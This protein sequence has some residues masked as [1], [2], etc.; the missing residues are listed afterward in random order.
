MKATSSNLLHWG[1]LLYF[2]IPYLIFIFFFRSTLEF[3]IP[4]MTWALKNSLFQAGT[5]AL[6]SLVLA[7]PFSQGLLA[8]PLKWQRTLSNLLLL[9]QVLPSLYTLL[10]VFSLLRPFPMG[11]IG[12][13][14]VFVTVNAGFASVLL[15][16][17]VQN[18]LGHLAVVS[19]VFSLGRLRFLRQVYLPLLLADFKNIFFL[20][21]VFCISSFAIP[22]IAGGGK[23]TNLEVLIYEK[24]FIEQNWSAAFFICLFQTLFVFLIGQ[25]ALQSSKTRGGEFVAS[26]YLKSAAGLGALLLYLLLFFGGYLGGLLESFSYFGFFR[27]YSGDLLPV[28]LYSLG[29]LLL[30]ILFNGLLLV[31]WL[32]DYLQHRRFTPALNLISVSTVVVGFSLYLFFPAGGAYDVPKIILA[33][34]LILFP[35][36]FKLFLQKP[37]ESIERQLSIARV[38]GLSDGSILYNIILRQ[39]KAPLRL[40]LSVLVFWFLSDYA[41]LKA[42]G[43]QKQ[44]LG[45]LTESYL[46]SYRLPLSY[47]MSGYIILLS[48]VFI[49]SLYFIIRLMNVVYKKFKI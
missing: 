18:K 9:P 47:L 17:A 2:F 44:T 23:G 36:L 15:A 30:Y 4:D 48:L 13:I 31:L 14:I 41:I 38:C 16:Q 6:V 43:V 1:L 28:T 27:Q 37:V 46:S 32:L 3:N 26:A 7:V 25:F 42:L 12:I 33:M 34:T 22:L 35:A 39:L 49:S 10:I 20:I 45:L 5:A 8:A 21:F 40:W 29:V 11:S 24:I 19:E